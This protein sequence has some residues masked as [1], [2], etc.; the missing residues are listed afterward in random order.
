MNASANSDVIVAN[1]PVSYDKYFTHCRYFV[2]SEFGGVYADIDVECLRPLDDVINQYDC[3]LSQEPTEHAHFI[4]SMD[5]PLVSN[6]LM[7]CR[8]GHPFF[9]KVINDLHKY[10]GWWN[11][12]DILHATGPFMLTEV[13]HRY[14]RRGL[15]LSSESGTNPVHLAPPS[16]FQPTVDDSMLDSMRE[17]CLHSNGHLFLSE[18]FYNRQQELC[19]RLNSVSFQNKPPKDGYTNHHWTH[20]WAGRRH[21]PWAVKNSR[22]FFQVES[23]LQDHG[24]K[25]K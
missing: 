13:Y 6:A 23:L 3:F 25:W 16:D 15:L 8:P 10:S 17:M 9:K 19:S 24:R 5:G 12:N 20:T 22:R 14:N 1:I 18:N 7:G 2:L 4:A 21:D 11:W